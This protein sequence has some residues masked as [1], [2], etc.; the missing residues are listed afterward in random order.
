MYFLE[1]LSNGT[2]DNGSLLPPFK[3]DNSVLEV[4]INGI[5]VSW[6]SYIYSIDLTWAS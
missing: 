6:S 1:S 5:W 4:L 2:V 3:I